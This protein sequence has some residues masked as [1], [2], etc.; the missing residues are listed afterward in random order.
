MVLK[1]CSIVH[2]VM[3]GEHSPLFTVTHRTND[4]SEY[5]LEATYLSQIL[6]HHNRTRVQIS[7]KQTLFYIRELFFHLCCV[8]L[9]IF[10]VQHKM[11]MFLDIIG[12]S[13]CRMMR[14][15]RVGE[16]ELLCQRHHILIS[17]ES[18]N[19]KCFTCRFSEINCTANLHGET[20]EI[21]RGTTAFTN[22]VQFVHINVRVH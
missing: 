5:N 3:T 17:R 9:D 19:R 1:N 6:A 22:T 14:K 7:V 2:C 16:D 10:V 4:M 15:K 12:A 18:T 21:R 20:D 8:H 11:Q 13:I